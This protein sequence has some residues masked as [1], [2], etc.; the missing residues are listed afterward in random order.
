MPHRIG[1]VIVNKPTF[2]NGLMQNAYFLYDIYKQLGHLCTLLVY[3]KECKHIKG[4]SS[5]P[6][7]HISIYASEFNTS[8]YDILIT[9]GIGISHEIFQS[10]QKTNTYVIGFVCGNVLANTVSGFIDPK[11]DTS[12]LIAK[13]TPVHKIWLIEGYRHMKTFIELTRSVPVTLVQHTWSP[14]LLEYVT[15]SRLRS[16][17]TLYYKHTHTPSSKY[18]IVILEPNLNYTKHAVI[19]F[20][21]CEYIHKTYPELINQVFIFN[22]HD[23]SKTAKHLLDTYSVGTKTRIFKNLYIDEILTYLNSQPNPFMVISYQLHNPWNYLYYEMLH[24]GIP[25]VHNSLDFK[26]FGYYY[27]ECSIE[28]GADAVR[29][30]AQYHTALAPLVKEKTHQLLNAMDPANPECRTYWNTLLENSKPK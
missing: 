8:D 29:N 30:A 27:P 22:W 16:V 20:T 14:S 17:D 15:K 2:S 12:G 3:D 25:L 28:G 18:N 13:E 10:C 19:P 1:F 7:K 11:N 23:A 6:V 9:I 21:I 26:Q 24:F 5:I 4:L